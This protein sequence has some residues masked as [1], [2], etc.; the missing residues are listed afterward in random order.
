MIVVCYWLRTSQIV[1]WRLTSVAQEFMVRNQDSII[2]YMLLT[3]QE[4]T[5]LSLKLLT[6]YYKYLYSL[7]KPLVV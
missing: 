1:L 7:S 3:N 5:F 6:E 4:K 2:S